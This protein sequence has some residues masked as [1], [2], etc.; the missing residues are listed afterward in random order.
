MTTRSSDKSG[1][2]DAV[3]GRGSKFSSKALAFGAAT[4]MAMSA[5]KAAEGA[6]IQV[7]TE[8]EDL[9]GG[10]LGCTDPVSTAVAIQTSNDPTVTFDYDTGIDHELSDTF[11]GIPNLE[12]THVI[13]AYSPLGTSPDITNTDFNYVPEFQ[14]GTSQTV[15]F[16]LRDGVGSGAYLNLDVKLL[17]YVATPGIN[18]TYNAS[19]DT[20]S[21]GIYDS[22]SSGNL[23]SVGVGGS[24][25]GGA[26]FAPSGFDIRT[27]NTTTGY[28]PNFGELTLTHSAVP[29]PGVLGSL[30]TGGLAV[31]AYAGK[32]LFSGKDKK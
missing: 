20:D 8:A 30:L 15:H 2:T 21:D 3:N 19:F 10:A 32:K 11:P 22:F 23:D 24:L 5:A 9:S 13:S 26:V 25:W 28:S 16:S 17:D 29:E 6:Y 4:A 31:A 14:D 1:L 27:V 12:D 18:T 7:G